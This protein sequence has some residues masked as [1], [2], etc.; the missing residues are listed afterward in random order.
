M[1][2]CFRIYLI[3]VCVNN[4]MK[5]YQEPLLVIRM[6]WMPPSGERGEG[7]ELEFP[8]V[9]TDLC[10]VEKNSSI[11]SLHGIFNLCEMYG[12]ALKLRCSFALV[13]F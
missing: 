8:L 3:S 13:L 2:H 9:A 1:L 11:H 7:I 5:M 4:N 12:E 10:L 6:R